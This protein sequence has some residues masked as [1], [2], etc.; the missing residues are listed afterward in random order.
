M[1]VHLVDGTYELFRQYLAPRPGHLD[2]SG[3][4]VSGVRGVVQS[5]LGLLEA[6]AT[7]VGVA[8]DHTVESFRNDLWAGYKTGE[9]LDP[10]LF[11]QFP[12]VEDALAA[13][14]V[15]VWPMVE[16]EADDGLASAAAVAVGDHRVTRV[17]VCTPD[18]DL[19]QCVG[20]K[21]V[22]F[23]RRREIVLDAAGI[24]DKYG[25]GPGVIPDWLA[26]VGD[27]ADGF[28]GLPGFGAKTAAALLERFGRLEAI[29]DDPGAWNGTGVRGATRLAGVLAEQRGD[30][31][32][33]KDLATLRRDAP[34]GSVDDWRWRGPAPGFAAWC[35]RLGSPRLGIRAERLAR[36]RGVR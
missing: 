19:A 17:F 29:P 26:L 11:A 28:P 20:G 9:G 12:L 15:A 22:M 14:G 24:R 7:H 5:V 25:V 21:V 35:E 4:E 10:D 16:Y 1:E 27:T 31:A 23:D 6:G 36:E 33:F 30:A 32:L 8:T 3:I 34:V 18:K 2:P 13:L